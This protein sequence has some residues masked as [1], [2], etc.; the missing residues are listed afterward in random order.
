MK[1]CELNDT[2]EWNLVKKIRQSKL[3]WKNHHKEVKKMF[4]RSILKFPRIH[5]R[6]QYINSS[7]TSFNQ[8][9]KSSRHARKQV[10]SKS[11]DTTKKPNNLKMMILKELMATIPDDLSKFKS[12]E[13]KF[14]TKSV[15][16][17]SEGFWVN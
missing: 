10:P 12:F 16:L 15:Y 14:E 5:S 3:R 4:Y 13:L 8:H 11:A 9:I 1:F 17:K 7:R 6:F 2:I